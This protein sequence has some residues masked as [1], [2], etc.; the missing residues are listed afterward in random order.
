MD[1]PLRVKLE[2]VCITK[3]A[4]TGGSPG[5]DDVVALCRDEST[6]TSLLSDG[7]KRAPIQEAPAANPTPQLPAPQAAPATPA[8]PPATP[9]PPSRGSTGTKKCELCSRLGVGPSDTHTKDWCYINPDSPAFKP[10]VRERRLQQARA[11]GITIPADIL[12]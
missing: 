5:W 12:A 4:H 11:R 7:E 8:A 9:K 3:K 1:W 2:M 10:D 6:R